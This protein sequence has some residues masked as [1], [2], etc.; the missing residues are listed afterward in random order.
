MESTIY[1][2]GSIKSQMFLKNSAKERNVSEEHDDLHPVVILSYNRDHMV[3]IIK[4]HKML[5][6]AKEVLCLHMRAYTVRPFV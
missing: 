2:G 1:L 4:T 6:C 5:C 3:Q